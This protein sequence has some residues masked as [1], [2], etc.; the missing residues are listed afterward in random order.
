MQESAQTDEQW[1]IK[2]LHGAK[3]YREQR[4]CMILI[5]DYE[6]QITYNLYA[7]TVSDPL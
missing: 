2:W 1:V 6:W 5:V 7:R 3:T 4:R